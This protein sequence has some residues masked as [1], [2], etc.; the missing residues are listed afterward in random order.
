MHDVLMLLAMLQN[1]ITAKSRKPYTMPM[2]SQKQF[3]SGQLPVA[4]TGL[5]KFSSPYNREVKSLKTPNQTR[6]S[7]K[8][9]RIILA[10]ETLNQ[11]NFSKRLK[12]FLVRRQ[13]RKAL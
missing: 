5:R 4:K 13:K 11:S 8:C 1:K 6:I 12:I 9:G 7:I 3:Q 10:T 2:K